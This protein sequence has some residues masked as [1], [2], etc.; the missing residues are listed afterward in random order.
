MVLP[1]QHTEIST[2]AARPARDD[3]ALMHEVGRLYELLA[4]GDHR[5]GYNVQ[6]SPS[7]TMIF[8]DGR[9][10]VVEGVYQIEAEEDEAAREKRWRPARTLRGTT[11][12]PRRFNPFV[13]SQHVLGRYSVGPE[14]AGWVQ[15]IALDIDAKANPN[16][17]AAVAA[18][19]ARA[20]AML[21]A[22][23]RAFRFGAHRQ[24][25]VFRSPGGGFHVWIPLTRGPASSNP[26]HTW[27]SAWVRGWVKLHLQESGLELADGSLELY[28]AGRRLRAPCGR[29]M[30]LLT[31]LAPDNPDALDLVPWAGTQTPRGRDV[32]AMVRAFCD[33]FEAR[34][35]TLAELLDRPEA[36]WDRFYGFFAW[37]SAEACAALASAKKRAAAATGTD[38]RSQQTD[39]VPAAGGGGSGEPRRRGKGSGAARGDR[40]VDPDPNSK[41]PTD[42]D[43]D[44]PPAPAGSL[45]KGPAFR[46]KVTR[47]LSEGLTEAARRH[48]A[49]MTL[50]FY[51]GATCGQ[52]R[53]AVLDSIERWCRRLGHAGSVTLHEEGLGGF[54]KTCLAE[55][56]SY[57]DGFSSR[58]PFRGRGGVPCAPLAVADHAV[59]AAVEYRVRAE[60][61]AVLSWFAGNADA[62]GWV[63][64]PAEL[65]HG[66]LRALCPDRRVVVDGRRRR[67]VVVAIEEL[68][69]IGILTEHAD[70]AVGKHG[71]VYS[72]WYR[73]GSGELP[74]VLAVPETN[75]EA[76]AVAGEVDAPSGAE[77]RQDVP[78]DAE[79]PPLV[80]A[81]R[82]VAEGTL[83]VLSDGT[84]A[85]PARVVLEPRAALVPRPSDATA[86]RP[87]W[88]ARL[89]ARWFSVGEFLHGD[90]SVVPLP[91]RR[92][93]RPVYP[94]MRESAAAPPA[95]IGELP[96]AAAAAVESRAGPTDGEVLALAVPAEL[97]AELPRELAQVLGGAWRS[98]LAR[99]RD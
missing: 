67:A 50:V 49:V 92:A 60:A 95:P 2:I 94:W 48:D 10:R 80:V 87:P 25:L 47:L 22:I 58:W 45:T 33:G 13:L 88:W 5:L 31:P 30:Q 51:Y 38:T 61:G 24:P 53:S 70:Y 89:Y 27:P 28:P 72:C 64:E 12:E 46:R 76:A 20:R 11:E 37:R 84:R 56:A 4:G 41:S 65:A 55:A 81:V 85:T 99:R 82:E 75:L 3:A 68:V 83:R 14:A 74:R 19:V 71:R 97:V 42:E 7:L 52:G 98:F 93:P 34:R 57:Y 79:A 69:R 77:A 96:T 73:F 62:V 39:E 15:W 32:V 1:N 35:L 21:A 17:A 54:I 43:P 40:S 26:E 44:Q 9:R 18:A 6:G 63:T 8:K 36:G 59:L 86:T 78:G 90:P 23:W 16:D 91:G 66:L 29:R